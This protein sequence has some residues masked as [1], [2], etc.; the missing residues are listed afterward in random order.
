MF[1]A[2]LKPTIARLRLAPLAL[3]PASILAWLVLTSAALSSCA[4]L[5]KAPPAATTPRIGLTEAQRTGAVCLELERPDPNGD[6]L[7]GRLP[8]AER[9][10]L[11]EVLAQWGEAEARAACWRSGYFGLVGVADTAD[12][13]WEDY[14]DDRRQH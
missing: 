3:T 12:A 1:A 5:P 8:T 10:F 11:G 14:A 4:G 13:A 9:L 7:R 6:G 2:M